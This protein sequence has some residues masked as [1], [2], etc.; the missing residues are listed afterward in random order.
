MIAVFNAY[1]GTA[2]DDAAS[3]TAHE[4]IRGPPGGKPRACLLFHRTAA[5]RD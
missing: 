1:L 3:G 4:I 2:T 5:A